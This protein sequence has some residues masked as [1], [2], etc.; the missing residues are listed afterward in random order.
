MLEQAIR[1]AREEKELLLM[2]HIVLGYPSF[3]DSARLVE[4]MVNA[5]VDL[6]ELQIPFSEPMADGAVILKAN[7][8]ALKAG[9]TV[10]RS[11]EVAEKLCAEFDIPFL[12][13]TYYNI[14]YCHGV[15]K[16]VDRCKSIGIQGC[17][18]PDLP[19]VE[20]KEYLDAMQ[21]AQLSPVHI[22]TPNTTDDRMRVLNDYSGG[23]I[24]AV[25]RKG[26]TGKDTAFS[27]D[28]AQYLERCRAHTQLPLA[29]GFGVKSR[30]DFDFLSGKSDIAVVGSETIR[31]MEKE[32][33]EGVKTFIDSLLSN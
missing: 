4:T 33:I 6:I 25:A 16:F 30:E 9:A 14:L 15:K 27:E 29:V 11:F 31:V 17:I 1:R 3:D 10:E 8:E 22:F 24:Y 19:P 5:G 20:G 21:A 7:S 18:I 28:I 13:M 2:T 32:G 23:F 12:F 26:V